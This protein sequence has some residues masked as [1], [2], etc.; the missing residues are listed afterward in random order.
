LL[1]ARAGDTVELATPGG[2]EAIEVIAIVYPDI[3]GP[4]AG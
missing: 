3:S 4:A 1:K 2:V